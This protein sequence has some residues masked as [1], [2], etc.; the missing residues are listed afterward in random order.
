MKKILSFTFLAILTFVSSSAFGQLNIELQSKVDYPDDQGNDVWGWVDEDGSEYAI[1]GTVNGVS[2][3]NISDPTDPQE[4]EF[5]DQQ[6]STWRDMKSW[7]DYVYV[8][9]DQAGT[10][11]GLLI[12]DMTNLPDS[13]S[14]RNL[15]LEIPDEG[16]VNTC[17]NLYIDEDGYLYLAG[18]AD[19][20][21]GGLIVLDV[22]S[23]P[24]DPIYVSKGSDIYSHDVYVRDGFAYSSQINNGDFAIYDVSNKDS[25]FV[26][27]SQT[28]PFSFTHNAWLSDD[29]NILFTTDELPNAPVA[30]YD[31]S[32]LGDIVLLDEYRPQ[33]T[34]GQGVIPHNVHVYQN[35]LVI[36][37]YSDGCIIV[38]ATKPDNLVE[39]G[40]YDTFLPGLTGFNGAWGA[41]PFFPSGATI[42]G[43]MGTPSADGVPTA[44]LFVLA[45]TYVRAGYLEGR[46]VE[47]GTGIPINNAEINIEAI[48]L[49]D[50][51]NAAGEYKTGTPTAGQ[52]MV[53]ASAFGYET[54]TRL[55]DIVNG[56][57]AIADFELAL[58]PR[59]DVVINVV[60]ASSNLP[61]ENVQVSLSIEGI[62][63]L[64]MTDADGN[65]QITDLIAGT[66]YEI[67]AGF[68][69]FNYSFETVDILDPDNPTTVNIA[70]EPGYQD[71][72]DLDLGW[73]VE[74]VAAQG[75]W[76]RG[77]PIGI[78]PQGAPIEI[79]PGSDSDDP[80]AQCYV[81]GNADDIISGL[82][83]GE[84]TLSSPIFDASQMIEPVINYDT[85]FWDS[86]S[87]GAFTPVADPFEI[88]LDNGIETVRVDSILFDLLGIFTGAVAQEWQAKDSVKIRDFLEPTDSMQIIVRIA[89]VGSN[90]AVEGGFD[91]FELYD[92]GISSAIDLVE[93]VRIKLYPNP[94]QN[95]FYVDV[96]E[97]F[98]NKES[99][100][101]LLTL[102]GKL[103]DSVKSNGVSVMR[104]GE[105]LDSGIYFVQF[106]NDRLRSRAEKVIKI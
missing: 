1:F 83:F 102:D 39:V 86:D 97:Q 74:S 2:V 60:E 18:C 6:P 90:S 16:E 87:Q 43:D 62:E 106:A 59:A 27:A 37:Y 105:E 5:I 95:A 30:S 48:N 96:P 10:T 8:T 84:T 25:I 88:Y 28:T 104:I 46:V 44:S 98:R 76:E 103:V 29:S 20:N 91:G 21:S 15:N 75:D 101:E 55:V 13:I 34:L 50:A 71:Y 47:A 92:I 94:S 11:D 85:W 72:F 45:P 31:I 58:A 54:A 100:L 56:E 70:L 33:T 38:D 19:L 99:R 80:G 64:A 22:F 66:G 32:D 69:G 42:I 82:L 26:V 77:F 3:V 23:T 41:Y 89:Q 36:S 14:Y 79:A 57:V 73:T 12:I 49:I 53:T 52:Y 7:G 24:G 4:V 81:T 61:L 78:Q 51:T 65:V 35:W 67:V 9:S 93:D 40:N 63:E 68:W 17:H